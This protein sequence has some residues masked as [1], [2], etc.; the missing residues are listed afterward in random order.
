VRLDFFLSKK[1]KGWC[2]IRIFYLLFFVK[3]IFFVVEEIRVVYGGIFS[4]AEMKA[5]NGDTGGI[6]RGA[7]LLGDRGIKKNHR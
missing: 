2:L 4:S 1:E 3:K 6:L 7:E 5:G